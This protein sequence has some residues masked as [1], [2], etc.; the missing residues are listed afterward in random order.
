MLPSH[1][2]KFRF[3]ILGALSAIGACVL[4]LVLGDG[5]GQPRN[6]GAGRK[7]SP[8]EGV[9]L[10]KGDL[11]GKLAEKPDRDSVAGRAVNANGKN[12]PGDDPAINERLRSNISVSLKNAYGK[13]FLENGLSAEKSDE[14]YSLLMTQ[15]LEM[16]G[17]LR[18]RPGG[19]PPPIQEV[20]RLRLSQQDQLR[21]KL[22]DKAYAA[23]NQFNRDRNAS[24]VVSRLEESARSSGV[25]FSGEQLEQVR[26][27]LAKERVSKID[28]SNLPPIDLEALRQNQAAP[29][30][31]PPVF[32]ENPVLQEVRPILTPEQVQLLDNVL[33]TR[34][35]RSPGNR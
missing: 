28:V 29:T 33:K 23:L 30:G 8:E 11:D 26:S 21:E 25:S 17:L 31:P 22:G 3:L 32:P 5:W 12:R 18:P 24:R 13:L 1:S 9:V 34:P 27:V 19:P 15:Q 10:P 4:I 20:E 2:T 16:L 6:T 35:P 7:P 14:V